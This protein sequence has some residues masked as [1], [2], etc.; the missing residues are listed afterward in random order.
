[1][2]KRPF[3]E[4]HFGIRFDAIALHFESKTGSYQRS[5]LWHLDSKCIKIGALSTCWL[6]RWTTHT[7]YPFVFQKESMWSHVSN[8]HGRVH[9]TEVR[10]SASIEIVE[11]GSKHEVEFSLFPRLLEDPRQYRPMQSWIWGLESWEKV[12]FTNV[13]CSNL[14]MQFFVTRC[15]CCTFCTTFQAQSVPL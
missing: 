11:L 14:V 4:E 12:V 3:C 1:M 9:V 10:P 5:N 2:I 7:R 8:A 13:K 6:S 15:V